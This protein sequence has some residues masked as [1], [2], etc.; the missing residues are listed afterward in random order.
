[1]FDLDL[2][3]RQSRGDGEELVCDLDLHTPEVVEMEKNSC[4]I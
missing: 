1:M 3:T 2:H 4:L